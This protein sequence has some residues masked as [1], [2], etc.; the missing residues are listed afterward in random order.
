MPSG[1]GDLHHARCRDGA[2][3]QA[4][5]PVGPRASIYGQSDGAFGCPMLVSAM[6][7]AMGERIDLYRDL[8]R[9]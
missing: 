8:G 9:R 3:L 4:V 5:T 7:Y 1:A 6:K 2:Q